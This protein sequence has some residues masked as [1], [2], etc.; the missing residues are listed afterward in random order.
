MDV[1][2]VRV[3][4]AGRVQGVWYRAWTVRRAKKLGLAGWVRNR[5]DGRAEALFSGPG[6]AVERMVEDCHSGPP[7]ARVDRIERS[8]AD[9]PESEEF[10]QLGD[11]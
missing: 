2:S 11:E 8:P 1:V 7:A 5:R 3:F 9:A 10:H 6:D 4:I